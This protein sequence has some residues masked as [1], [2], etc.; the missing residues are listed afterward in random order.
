MKIAIAL[1]GEYS[2]LYHKNHYESLNAHLFGYILSDEEVPM[3]VR[4]QFLNHPIGVVVP[5]I[6]TA[7][8]SY[9]RP[10]IYSHCCTELTKM[11]DE[12]EKEKGISY[13]IRIFTNFKTILLEF[14]TEPGVY[15]TQYYNYVNLQLPNKLPCIEIVST[16]HVRFNGGVIQ[17]VRDLSVSDRKVLFDKL[18][19]GCVYDYEN[20]EGGFIPHIA[21]LTPSVINISGNPFDYVNYRSVFTPRERLAQTVKQV[22]SISEQKDMTSF[23]LEG[24]ELDLGQLN[25]LHKKGHY[26]ILF[27]R[28]VNGNHYANTH[29]NKSIYEIYVMRKML[30]KLHS[31]ENS[32]AWYFKF[33][34]RYHLTGSFNLSQFLREKPV[35]KIV[36]GKYTFAGQSIVEC[37]IYSFPYSCREKYLGIYGEI[38][39]RVENSSESIESLLYEKSCDFETV[40]TLGV[41]GKDAIEGFDQ[42]V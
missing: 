28:D 2:H 27:C 7:H 21:C 3:L 41:I 30:E 39:E 33:G 1:Y 11:I 35:Y 34:G 19:N 23:V 36:D 29:T 37:I 22:E 17:R 4:T 16:T 12:Y 20:F 42:L 40:N 31:E 5:E 15:H 8:L 38:T 18:F 32:D 6:N 26:I 24:S 13:D 25:D 14:P 9:R 10:L